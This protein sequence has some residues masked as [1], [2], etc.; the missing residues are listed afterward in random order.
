MAKYV[1]CA[2]LALASSFKTH[3]YIFRRTGLRGVIKYN[4]KK[5]VME[6]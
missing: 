2:C 4:G 5:S 3:L 1:G 6:N